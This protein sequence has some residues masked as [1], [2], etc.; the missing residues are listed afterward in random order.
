MFSCSHVSAEAMELLALT[1]PA[2][3]VALCWL[4][5]H[6][7]VWLDAALNPGL[8]R[9]GVP[10]LAF[11]AALADLCTAAHHALL[12]SVCPWGPLASFLPGA[13]IS[14]YCASSCARTCRVFV[15]TI[16]TT[17]DCW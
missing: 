4:Q 12:Q 9:G 2:V 8:V 11:W 13:H 3:R 15:A 5:D 16:E 1:L 6:V 7:D 17:P 10:V 14:S